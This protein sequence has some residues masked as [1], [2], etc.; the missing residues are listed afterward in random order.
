M[1][2]AFFLHEGFR[3]EFSFNTTSGV[4]SRRQAALDG[5]GFLLDRIV[6]L[7]VEILVPRSP[8][9]LPLHQFD[10]RYPLRR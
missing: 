6:T 1:S 9:K 5:S 2:G 7:V 10:P 3:P 4:I 8:G